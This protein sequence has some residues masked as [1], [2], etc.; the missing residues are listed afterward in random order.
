MRGRGE[1]RESVEGKGRHGE[2][3]PCPLSR[4]LILSF[5]SPSPLSGVS[6]CR[7][8][9][10]VPGPP[11]LSLQ[12]PFWTSVTPFPNI[13]LI[14][15]CL[16]PTVTPPSTCPHS[17]PQTHLSISHIPSSSPETS[18]AF[19]FSSLCLTKPLQKNF[20]VTSAHILG[21][22]LLLPIQEGEF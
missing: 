3:P 9:L 4:K 13:C 22:C 12:S 1:E 19:R 15:S 16:R 20:S 17:Q 11:T 6:H 18:P 2:T 10:G 8:A 7:C 14:S 5:P 21:A